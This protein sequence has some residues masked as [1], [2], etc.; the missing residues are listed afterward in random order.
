MLAT[1]IERGELDG[2]LDWLGA[3]MADRFADP[4]VQARTF[5]ALILA[6][7]VE[8]GRYDEHWARAFTAW[9]P[10]ETDLRG[11]DPELGWLHAVAHGADLLGVLGRD[12][13]GQ[14]RG[15][16]RARRPQDGRGHRLRLA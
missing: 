13:P 8:R 14:A 6:W 7:V 3:A 1:W 16:A 5:A 12:Q 10:A 11:Y 4:Q 2:Q 9:Y 15:H